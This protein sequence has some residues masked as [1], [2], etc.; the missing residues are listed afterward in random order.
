MIICHCTA[1]SVKEVEESFEISSSIEDV[2]NITGAGTGCESCLPYVQELWDDYRQ[3]NDRSKS[4]SANNK[5]SQTRDM[6][7]KG[8]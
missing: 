5:R 7:N 6:D 1:A 8:N 2:R 4:N 3:K